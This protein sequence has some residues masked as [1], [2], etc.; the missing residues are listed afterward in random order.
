MQ[1][2]L[3]R[4]TE[5]K[6]RENDIATLESLAE[7]AV[8]ASLCA[9][10]STAANPVLSTFRYF[11]DEYEAHIAKKR[12]PALSCKELISYYID[13]AKCTAC[14]LC[15]KNCPDEA[16]DGDKKKIHI[17]DQEKCTNCG[18]CLD[19]CPP[20]IS[21]VV[22]ISGEPIPAPIPEDQRMIARKESA[23][24]KRGK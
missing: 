12:C 11:K 9:L 5:G 8:E 14:R 3:T 18:T 13:P 20:K 23:R 21:A 24:K 15:L 6:G 4:I 19:V 10:G 16:I 22:K 1:K 2:I 17:I 7:A